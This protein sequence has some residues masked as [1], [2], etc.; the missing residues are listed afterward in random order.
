ME[1]NSKLVV[2]EKKE[3]ILIFI[4]IVVIS[5]TAFT[6]GVRVGKELSLKHD[7]YTKDDVQS[8]DLKS[9]EEEYVDKVIDKPSSSEFEGSVNKAKDTNQKVDEIEQ[10]LREEMEKLA[11]DKEDDESAMNSDDDIGEET[12]DPAL[13]IPV[14]NSQVSSSSNQFSGK[15]TIQLYSNQSKSAAEDFADPFIIKGYNVIINEAVIP[16]K[17]TW[18]RVSIGV[19]ESI[20]EA[21][22]YLS[23][24]S[25]LFKSEDYIIQQL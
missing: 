7:G 6:L 3:V 23:A 16:G 12:V 1:D 22:A 20:E 17:G 14:E 19:F 13:K 5:V 8:I 21:K 9:V 25:K 4:F 2:F 15:Y 24:E 11:K 18:Y 10:R